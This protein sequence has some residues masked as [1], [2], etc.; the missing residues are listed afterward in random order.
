MGLPTFWINIP[1]LLLAYEQSL[2]DRTT[3]SVPIWLWRE[4]QSIQA[5][6]HLL[7]ISKGKKSHQGKTTTEG[8]RKRWVV[9]HAEARDGVVGWSHVPKPVTVWF[10]GDKTRAVSHWV[11]VFGARM[12]RGTRLPVLFGAVWAV[13]NSCRVVVGRREHTRV[14]EAV[15]GGVG[16]GR[17]RYTLGIHAPGGAWWMR[18]PEPTTA[19]HC[20]G[21]LRKS[22]LTAARWWWAGGY[23]C[24]YARQPGGV[25]VGGWQP[26]QGSCCS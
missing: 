10:G 4:A 20:G 22:K 12:Y 14:Y 21:G 1:L 15:W 7:V 18:E 5:Q 24:G 16:S 11:V 6:A 26:G 2:W 19:G 25:V 3:L 23:M 9:A 17:W 13:V 8:K